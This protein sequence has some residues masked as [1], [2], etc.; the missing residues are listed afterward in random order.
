VEH[1]T[2]LELGKGGCVESQYYD[3]KVLGAP[4]KV[5]LKNGVTKTPD[6]VTGKTITKIE[7]LPGLIA[8]VVQA[9][10]WH[11]RK[12]SG[13]EL[14]FI[15]SALAVKSGQ[16]AKIL[17]VT[18]EH[19]S[20]C[21]NGSKA[22]SISQEKLYR[23]FVQVCIIRRDKDL[24]DAVDRVKVDPP[25]DEEARR[26]SEMFQRL[27][28]D[29]KITPVFS[30]DDELVFEFKRGGRPDCDDCR[31]GDWSDALNAA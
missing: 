17:D 28:F 29:M 6:P 27:F 16:L 11:K 13:E 18:P 1:Q 26:S 15:R 24:K 4:F 30:P 12:L 22:M 10:I 31:G 19:Y 25:S 2:Q 3:A 8:A 9:R 20:R 21:E 5:Y 7:D 23:M 14:K